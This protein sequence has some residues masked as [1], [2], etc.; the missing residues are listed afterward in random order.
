[1]SFGFDT[2]LFLV[3]N[4]KLVVKY[5]NQ[6]GNFWLWEKRKYWSNLN[7][8]NDKC[9][10]KTFESRPL[11]VHIDIWYAWVPLARSS[12]NRPY[13]QMCTMIFTQI[14][15]FRAKFGAPNQSN[16]TNNTR[17]PCRTQR[18]L[19]QGLLL[20]FTRSPKKPPG[21]YG[22]RD[23]QTSFSCSQED[24]LVMVQ[25]EKDWLM[26]SSLIYQV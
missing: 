18:M 12:S 24:I 15:Y 17:Q 6:S 16:P 21:K 14:M 25:L 2:D 22:R 10:F 19:P 3:C 8:S 13:L 4:S 11:S 23:V 1:M 7:F 26:K 9:P 5:L 20:L